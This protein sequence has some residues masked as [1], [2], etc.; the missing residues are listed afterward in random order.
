MG[1]YVVNS[2]VHSPS[3]KAASNSKAKRVF[4]IE[5]FYCIKDVEVNH[6]ISSNSIEN[7]LA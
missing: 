6:V 7:V 3:I 4:F 1:E 2:L 5:M